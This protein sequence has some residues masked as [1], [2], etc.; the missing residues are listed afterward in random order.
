[1]SLLQFSLRHLLIAV[2]FV[3]VACTALL[4]ANVWWVGGIWLITI[5]ALVVGVLAAVFRRGERQ[6]FWIGFAIVGWLCI[7]AGNDSLPGLSSAWQLP[8]QTV[9]FA[10]DR[11]PDELRMPYIEEQTGR[12]VDENNAPAPMLSYYGSQEPSVAN[13][14]ARLAATQQQQPTFAPN[15]QFIPPAYFRPIGEALWTLVLAMC[16]GLLAR[17]IYRLEQARPAAAN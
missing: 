1:M 10:Y 13:A 12:P 9:Q 14:I 17:W 11:L 2:A 7:A 15:P 5:G 6:A 8:Q 16:G 3:A 4:N